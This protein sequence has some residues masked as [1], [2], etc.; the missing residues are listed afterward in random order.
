MCAIYTLDKQPILLYTKGVRIAI[1]LQKKRRFF[2]KE[3]RVAI[4]GFGGI[5]RSHYSGYKLL[6]RENAPV[7]VVAVCDIDL[8][9]FNSQVKIN[10]EA[11]NET[12]EKNIRTYTDVDEMLSKEDFDM[13]DICLPSYLHK[14]FTVKLLNAGKHVMCEKPMALSSS[15]CDEMID[16][17]NASGKKLMICQ[18][19]RFNAVY[20]Y[21]KD[22]VTDGRFGKL[23]HL[24][25]YRRSGQPRWGFENW[26]TSTERSGGCILDMHIHD[27]DMARY[28]LGDPYA[29]SCISYDTVARWAVENSRL[30]YNGVMVVADGS[31]N[32]SDT[33]K[34]Q[35]GFIARFENA[36]VIC[37]A[38]GLKVYPDRGDVFIPELPKTNHMA[39]EIRFFAS[40]ILDPDM[41]NEKN[42]PKS[43]RETVRLIEK[44]RESAEKNGEIIKL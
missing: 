27:I 30:Y 7:R 15:D 40:T 17:A 29:V 44:L 25:M 33:A 1:S 24:Y 21:L 19:L 14:E 43:A 10:I 35:S 41:K 36:E 38:S 4:I 37:D 11:D 22:A 5:A 32:E 12:L 20:S 26:F 34:F 2:M 9:R 16:A 23:V 39:E 28:L 8:S 18:C 3:V 42:P 31:W 6:E 13:A